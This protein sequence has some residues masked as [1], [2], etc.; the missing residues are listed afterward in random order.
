MQIRNVTVDIAMAIMQ[1]YP[2]LRLL[3]EAYRSLVCPIG[4]SLAILNA[5]GVGNN[6][7]S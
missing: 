7:W 6:A 5:T 4:W 3:A 1:R 2:T